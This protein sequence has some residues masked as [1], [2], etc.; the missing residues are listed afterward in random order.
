MKTRKPTVE[1]LISTM[2][3]ID[4]GFLN[5]IF[6]HYN[7]ED[8]R[9]LVINQTTE[10]KQLHSK[11]DNIRV[12]NSF[13]R[14]LSKSRNLALENAIGDICCIADD[15]IEYLPDAVDNVLQAYQDYPE[16]AFIS[17]QFLDRYGKGY[18]KYQN[19]SK[20]Q[21]N[22]L[23]KQHLHSIEITLKPKI[24]RKRQIKF[25]TCFGIGATF[26]CGEEE[27]LR[28]DIV[29]ENLQVV[30]VKK[31]I[32]KHMDEASVAVEGS[33]E[34]TQ[35]ITALKYRLHKNLIYLWLLRY[36]W[37][38]LRQKFIKFS[39]VKQIWKYGVDAV[40]AYKRHCKS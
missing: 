17:F 40:K 14:G 34:Y 32:V 30:F 21:N 24:L 18:I 2:Y 5:S 16:A 35:A 1:F 15:D 23:H 12:I 31:P 20:I 8:L 37:L 10:D 39:Q 26:S 9:V 38:L 28:D 22:L 25:N 29:R 3:R 19:E 27:V 36:I 7:L 11:S 33:K 13:E 6:K 4:F